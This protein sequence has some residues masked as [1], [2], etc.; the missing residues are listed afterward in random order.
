[1]SHN[2]DVS[3]FNAQL[4]IL[5]GFLYDI[6]NAGTDQKKKNSEFMH[7]FNL[8]K[9]EFDTLQWIFVGKNNQNYITR[10]PK[11]TMKIVR[12]S[13]T[14]GS[15]FQQSDSQNLKGFLKLS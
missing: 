15:N 14:T 9:Y 1:L 8:K 5:T 10:F 7:Y 4:V 12:F 11:I 3:K 13:T 6:L 2:K